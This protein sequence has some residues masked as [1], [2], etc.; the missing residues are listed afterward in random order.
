ML[1]VHTLFYV[2]GICKE[3]AILWI[4]EICITAQKKVHGLIKKSTMY[5]GLKVMFFALYALSKLMQAVI[6]ATFSYIPRKKT[7]GNHMV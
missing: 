4:V 5:Y 7:M 6:F 1:L 2:G 3:G